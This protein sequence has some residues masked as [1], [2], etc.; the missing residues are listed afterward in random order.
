MDEKCKTC[1][2]WMVLNDTQQTGEGECVK[3][4]SLTS[5]EFACGNWVLDGTEE[6]CPH[7]GKP[8]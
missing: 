1:G 2:R 6:T 3:S 7:C 8:L 4:K 5:R